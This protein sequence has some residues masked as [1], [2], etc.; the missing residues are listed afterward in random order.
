MLFWVIHINSK[1]YKKE[2]LPGEGQT[3]DAIFSDVSDQNGITYAKS[4][5]LAEIKNVYKH[6]KCHVYV[7]KNVTNLTGRS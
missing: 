1:G 4:K 5:D 7:G 6:R 3:K 2:T